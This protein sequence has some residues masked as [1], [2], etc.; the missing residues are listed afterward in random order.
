LQ[1]AASS[2]IGCKVFE[3]VGADSVKRLAGFGIIWKVFAV[4]EE[5]RNRVDT[6][7]YWINILRVIII[8]GATSFAR[9]LWRRLPFACI[10]RAT[11]ASTFASIVAI[12]ESCRLLIENTLVLQLVA[13]GNL[14]EGTVI[15]GPVIVKYVG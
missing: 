14:V 12:E 7:R 8:V 13:P 4:V 6:R 10:A 11:S 9:F 2:S 5:C 15:A 3:N 1:G